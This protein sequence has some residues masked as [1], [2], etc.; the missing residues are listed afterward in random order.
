LRRGTEAGLSEFVA[1]VQRTVR[2]LQ[3]QPGYPVPEQIQ[4]FGGGA[5]LPGVAARIREATGIPAAPWQ[6][7]GLPTALNSAESLLAPAIALSALG[8]QP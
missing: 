5:C 1:E 8:V 3:S 4:L 2:F 7:A 6:L